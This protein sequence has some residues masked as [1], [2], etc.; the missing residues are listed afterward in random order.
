MLLFVVLAYIDSLEVQTVAAAAGK[1]KKRGD[2]LIH[3]C[4]AFNFCLYI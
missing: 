4:I 2:P 3:V 1:E